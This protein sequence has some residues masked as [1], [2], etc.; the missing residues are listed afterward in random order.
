MKIF[1]STL[2]VLFLSVLFVNEAGAQSIK[3]GVGMGL[4]NLQSPQQYTNGF[5]IENVDPN[6]GYGTV[7]GYGLRNGYHFG[8]E[9]KFNFPLLP[10]TPVAFIDYHI[11]KG[12]G[13]ADSLG[14]TT[15]LNII[16]VGAEAEFFI[17]HLPFVSPYVAV[18]ISENFFGKLETDVSQTSLAW[19]YPAESRTGGGLGV[20]AEISLPPIDFDLSLKYN[21]FNLIG[22]SS[23]EQ[24][25]NSLNLN[26]ELLF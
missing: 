4:T 13:N 12:S 11:L 14:Y 9:A 8:I 17:I 1:F 24:N 25:I 3:I 7:T 18:N 10:I 2:L 6:S 19:T 20:G 15:S 5:A 22:K 23:G 21:Y 16:S 26:L